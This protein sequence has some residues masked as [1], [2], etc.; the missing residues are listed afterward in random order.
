MPS[1][2]R[3]TLLDANLGN[4]FPSCIKYKN[5]L[6]HIKVFKR[7]KQNIAKLKPDIIT[8]QEMLA[9]WQCFGSNETNSDKICSYN[10]KNPVREL[11]GK[12]YTIVGNARNEFTYIAVHKKFGYIKGIPFGA[13][14]TTSR[15]SPMIGACD[16][17]FLVMAVTVQTH[18]QETFDVVNVHLPSKKVRAPCRTW[19]IRSIFEKLPFMKEP[20]IQS[21]NVII[22]GDFNFDPWRENG[23][24]IQEWNKY[25]KKGWAGRPLRYISGIVEKNPPYKTHHN[26]IIIRTFDF[27][28]SNFIEDGYL[29]VLGQSPGTT[30]LDGGQ[31]CDH[32]ALY[33]N[34]GFKSRSTF[35][36][37]ITRFKKLLGEI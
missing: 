19:L 32:M 5:N 14:T 29:K 7:L 34:L 33:G 23:E 31:G 36:R 11:L 18:F 1:T 28:V 10:I 4:I 3:F 27:A 12:D 20:L 16:N 21:K 17:D 8:L 37:L 30:R 13:Y 24:V 9:P 26:K 22:V 15:I 25:F 6:C 2:I 35:R